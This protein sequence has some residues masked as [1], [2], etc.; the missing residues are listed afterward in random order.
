M[1]SYICTHIANL[2]PP[3]TETAKG[4]VCVFVFPPSTVFAVIAVVMRV[5]SSIGGFFTVG[6]VNGCA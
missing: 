5:A 3:L 6:G 4:N 1:H 2:L